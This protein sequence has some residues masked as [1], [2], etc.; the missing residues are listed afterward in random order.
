MTAPIANPNMPLVPGY[1]PVNHQSNV[2][3]AVKNIQTDNSVNPPVTYGDLGVD[4]EVSISP[5]SNQRVNAQAGDFLDGAIATLGLEADTAITNPASSG[6]AMAFFKGLV[7]ILADIWDSTNHLFA[8]NVKQIGGVN[9]QMMTA[10]AVAQ[11]NIPEQGLGLATFSNNVD[12]WRAVT[13]IA[14]GGGTGAA[15]MGPSLYNESNWDR[16]R[17]NTDNIAIFASAAHTTTQTSADQTNY[18]ARGVVVVLDMTVV[19]TGSVTLEIDG[20]DPVS[21]KYYAILTGATVTSNSTNVYTV[22]PSNTVTANVSASTVLPRT[23]R[24]KV[25]AN[26]ANSATYSVGAMLVL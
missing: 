18:N 14:D 5:S 17:N 15:T 22:Y 20:K 24:V 4:V 1:D 3:I 11:A 10:D 26:N 2:A 7:K 19:G 6:T 25:T 23:W 8:I 13:N 12:R 16:Q 9:T 21:G